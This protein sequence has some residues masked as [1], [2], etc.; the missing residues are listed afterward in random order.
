MLALQ[1]SGFDVPEI[2]PA[3]NGAAFRRVRTTRCA[4]VAPGRCVQVDR[5]VRNSAAWARTFPLMPREL[6]RHVPYHRAARRAA[7]QPRRASG[8]CRRISRG[9]HGT[10]RASWASSRSG[11][12]SGTSRR[13]S[14]EERALVVRGAGPIAPRSARAGKIPGGLRAHPRGLRARESA[15]RRRQDA[16]SGFRRRGLRLASVRDRDVALFP[17]RP[18][19]LRSDPRSDHSGLQDGTAAVRMSNS[20]CCRCF[21][22]PAASL[23]SAGCTPARR[24]KPRAS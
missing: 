3:R 12:A 4:R 2:V 16:T 14:P 6:P 15:G 13:L 18:A 8:H 21:S 5:A 7:A 23:I 19:V 22:P 11:V 17:H 10:P 20:R 1:A 24:R 9:M